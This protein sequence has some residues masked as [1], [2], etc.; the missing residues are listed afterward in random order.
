MKW[1]WSLIQ[2]LLATLTLLLIAAGIIADAIQGN[3]PDLIVRL[4]AQFL[5]GLVWLITLREW[6]ASWRDH[7]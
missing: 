4:G 6:Y 5:F 3:P 7:E 1:N 2:F